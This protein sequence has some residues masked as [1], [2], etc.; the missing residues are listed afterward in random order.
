LFAA[1]SRESMSVATFKRH[2]TVAKARLQQGFFSTG[3][4]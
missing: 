1:A 2:S 4:G 3:A